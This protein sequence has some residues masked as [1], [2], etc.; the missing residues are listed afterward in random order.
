MSNRRNYERLLIQKYA[1]LKLENGEVIAGQTRNISMGGAFLECE[2]DIDLS[3][4]TECSIS[5]ILNEGYE[6]ELTEIHGYI[7]H[8]G[9]EGLGLNFL[10][11]DSTY[12][13]FI[14]E[15]SS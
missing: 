15:S 2:P 11:V 13:Q 12:Y 8:S 6:E 1:L 7:S 9:T 3:E 4:G 5:L 10:K 14:D